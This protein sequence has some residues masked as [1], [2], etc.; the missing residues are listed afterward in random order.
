[1]VGDAGSADATCERVIDAIVAGSHLRFDGVWQRPQQILSRL[2]RRVP[3]LFVEEPFAA[4]CDRDELREIDGV[5]V[6]RP[7]RRRREYGVVD[8]MTIATDACVG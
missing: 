3:V 2:A 5:T 4:A 1:M 7:L 8:A 6:L